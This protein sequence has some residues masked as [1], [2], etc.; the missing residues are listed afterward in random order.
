MGFDPAPPID[1]M[2]D[3]SMQKADWETDRV[4]WTLYSKRFALQFKHWLKDYFYR[5]KPAPDPM[6]DYQLF[7]GVRMV[8]TSRRYKAQKELRDRQVQLES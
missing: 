3:C 2:S 6:D 7:Y 8:K 1:I 4:R 5:P